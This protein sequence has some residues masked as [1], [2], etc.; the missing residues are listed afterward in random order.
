ME[1][2]GKVGGHHIL[3]PGRGGIR[4]LNR[5]QSP[6]AKSPK[7]NQIEPNLQNRRADANVC[8]LGGGRQNVMAGEAPRRLFF[9]SPKMHFRNSKSACKFFKSIILHLQAMR[10]N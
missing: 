5:R 2:G 9:S 10:K 4:S 6:I 3:A 7:S 8:S 1:W